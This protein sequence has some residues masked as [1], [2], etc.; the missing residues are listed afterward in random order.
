MKEQLI[1]H[2][3]GPEEDDDFDANE[4]DDFGTVK[5]LGLTNVQVNT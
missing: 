5:S 1:P 3:A 4:R 2:D